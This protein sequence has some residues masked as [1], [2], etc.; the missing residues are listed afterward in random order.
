[1]RTLTHDLRIH[2]QATELAVASLQE[3]AVAEYLDDRLG[4]LLTDSQVAPELAAL[5]HRR[6]EG[7]PLFMRSLVDWWIAD[8]RLDDAGEAGIAPSRL[9]EL[10]AGVPETVRDLIQHQLGQLTAQEQAVLEAASVAGVELTTAAL[11]VALGIS[12]E[13]VEAVWP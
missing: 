6:T 4:S 7:N 1:L 11:T 13:D 12:E 5:V 3:A 8:G 2:G 9:A 10:E